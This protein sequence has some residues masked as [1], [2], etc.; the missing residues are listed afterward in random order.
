MNTSILHEQVV[1]HVQQIHQLGEEEAKLARDAMSRG[2]QLPRPGQ[3][4]CDAIS[5]VLQRFYRSPIDKG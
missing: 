4:R 2:E 5:E 3:G 1:A